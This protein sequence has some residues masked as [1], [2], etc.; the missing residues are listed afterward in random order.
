M[1]VWEKRSKKKG[2]GG[3]RR[4]NSQEPQLSLQNR[5]DPFGRKKGE[6]ARKGENGWADR[7]K[8]SEG[9]LERKDK[10]QKKKK[11]KKKKKRKKK[12]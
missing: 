5:G 3:K 8:A 2:G 10:T 6:G 12:K 11:K 9:L 4:D 1:T 7:E